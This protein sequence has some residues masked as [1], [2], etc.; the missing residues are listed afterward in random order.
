MA[1]LDII[2]PILKPNNWFNGFVVVKKPNIKLRVCLHLRPLNK[3]IKCKHL[4]L[5]TI[6]KISQM[7]G[8]SSFS[9]LD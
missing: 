1:D 9:K 8:A 7:S 2:E 4:H 3:A 6:K 5:P